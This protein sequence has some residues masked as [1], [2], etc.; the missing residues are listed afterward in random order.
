MK[1]IERHFFIVADEKIFNRQSGITHQYII[2]FVL[3]VPVFLRHI[4]LLSVRVTRL[5]KF[6]YFIVIVNLVEVNMH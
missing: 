5:N 3:F 4:F 6:L 2:L 1:T